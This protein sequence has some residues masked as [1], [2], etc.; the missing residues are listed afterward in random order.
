MINQPAGDAALRDTSALVCRYLQLT[1]PSLRGS[2]TGQLGRR[3]WGSGERGTRERPTE[4]E[5][6]GRWG[7]ARVPRGG[8]RKPGAGARAC[9]TPGAGAGRGVPTLL[10]FFSLCR[11]LF[12][13]LSRGAGSCSGS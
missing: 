9:R 2:Q 10:Y 13:G 11:Y 5:Q 8:L 6:V 4:G 1:F 12:L 7:P 3:E